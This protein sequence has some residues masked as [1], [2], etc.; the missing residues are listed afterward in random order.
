MPTYSHSEITSE[1]GSM[2][3]HF[4]PFEWLRVSMHQGHLQ[5]VHRNWPNKMENRTIHW[6]CSSKT[7]QV[8]G[9]FW[10]GGEDNDI[11]YNQL[12]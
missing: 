1:G 5:T 12:D 7:P 11:I 9:C 8:E 4:Q 6:M 10:G 2:E 3:H